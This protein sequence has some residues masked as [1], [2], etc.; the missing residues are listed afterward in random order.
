MKDL[1][2]LVIV[3]DDL[4]PNARV[5][6]M[7]IAERLHTGVEYGDFDQPLD[8]LEER[9]QELADALVYGERALLEEKP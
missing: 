7:R 8:W 5:V 4:G 6:L 2:R 1:E 3:Y 9:Q